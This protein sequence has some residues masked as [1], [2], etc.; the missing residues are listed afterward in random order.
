VHRA[1]R[2]PLGLRLLH[3]AAWHTALIAL[4]RVDWIDL[5]HLTEQELNVRRGLYAQETARAPL[6]PGRELRLSRLARDHATMRADRA[7]REASI[8]NDAAM[9][10]MHQANAVRWAALRDRAARAASLYEE[11][12][13]TRQDW[14]R[15][16]ESTLCIAQ[17]A[18]LEL[19][20][21]KPWARHDPL[22]SMEPESDIVGGNPDASDADILTALGLTP[23]ATEL[24]AHP[25]R[26]AEAVRQA[27]V[28]L[29]ELSTLAQPEED[30]ELMQAEAWGRHA[31]QQRQ[32]VFQPARPLV[33]PSERLA[34]LE[35]GG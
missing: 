26:I 25:Q 4:A 23:E 8:A 12:M 15:I 5:S 16:A 11:A 31:A 24:S 22:K 18:D 35:A 7:Q 30:H 19:R 9:K 6:H 1:G 10:E 32:A 14:H 28:R 29:D 3:R 20:R 2:G 33:R 27:Q 34:E 13:T 21:R 17:A